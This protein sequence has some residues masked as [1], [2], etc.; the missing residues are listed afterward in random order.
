MSGV[1]VLQHVRSHARARGGVSDGAVFD[2]VSTST[3]VTSP[4]KLAGGGRSLYWMRP[5]ASVHR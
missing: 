2:S 5:C 3:R 4:L 1:H